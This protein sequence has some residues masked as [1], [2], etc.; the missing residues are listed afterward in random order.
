MPD[1]HRSPTVRRRRLAAELRRLREASSKTHEDVASELGWHRS[2]LSRIE[3]A[4]FVRISLTDLRA[5]LDLYGVT[6]QTQRQ[7]LIT[8]GQEGRERGWWHSYSDVLPNPHSTLIGLEAETSSIRAYQAQLV[9]GLLQTEGYMRAILHAGLMTANARGEIDRFVEIRKARQALL[10][11]DPPVALWAVLDEAVLRRLIGGADVMRDQVERLIEVSELPSINV[12]VLPDAAGEHPGLEG[13]FMI[14]SFTESDPDA[15]YLDAAIGGLYIE[16][17]EDIARYSW[18]F[19][20]VRAAALSPRD[21]V[22]LMQ[23]ALNDLP[24]GGGQA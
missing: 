23:Q 5:L 19:D 17:P 20:H 1:T 24:P 18:I 2:K 15:V 8:L 22:R 10:T 11:Q 3:G 9:P 7:S 4:Q 14:L 6:D 12:Q 21:T 13:S 16:K